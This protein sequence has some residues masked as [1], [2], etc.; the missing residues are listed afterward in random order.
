[1][2]RVFEICYKLP[3]ESAPYR[4]WKSKWLISKV[5]FMFVVARPM[6][7]I[8]GLMLFDGKIGLFTFT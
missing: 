4:A 1:M 6:F 7:D 8:D 5:M 2:T 3:I